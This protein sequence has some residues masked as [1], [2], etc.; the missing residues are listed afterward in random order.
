MGERNP[1]FALIDTVLEEH[2]ELIRMM[3]DDVCRGSAGSNFGRQ[4]TPSVE[5]IVRGAIYKQMRNIDYA[6][7]ERHQDD[8]KIC[9]T[10]LK[11]DRK[12]FSE[13][14]WQ[15]YIARISEDSLDKLMVSLNKIAIGLGYED[16]KKIVEDSTVVE[17]NIHYPTNNALMWERTY[18]SMYKGK[19]SFAVA[20]K[21]GNRPADQRSDDYRNYMVDAKKT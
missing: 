14:T 10:F 12:I 2:P 8:S 21:R 4:D 6:D 19:P 7:F 13:K 18:G 17:T 15:K 20:P 11:L 5:Q 9:E 1:E 3:K 16:L